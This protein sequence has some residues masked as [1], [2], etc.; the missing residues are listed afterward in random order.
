MFI[1]LPDGRQINPAAIQ[2]TKPNADH[3]RVTWLSGRT[4]DFGGV[5][6]AEIRKGL[7]APKAPRKTK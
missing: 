6:A 5:N 1:E 3:L 4:E 2:D 7:A